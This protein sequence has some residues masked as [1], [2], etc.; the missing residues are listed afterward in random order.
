M[1]IILNVIQY[2]E[3][4]S[5]SSSHSDLSDSDS[6]EELLLLDNMVCLFHLLVYL[7]F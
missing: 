4:L 6:D 2:V 7:T 1:E 3:L 5:D